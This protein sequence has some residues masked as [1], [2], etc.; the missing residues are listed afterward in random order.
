[1]KKLYLYTKL[2]YLM[3]KDR[4]YESNRQVHG[5]R[6][7][8]QGNRKG[9]AGS[10]KEGEGNR[11]VHVEMGGRNCRQTGGALEVLDGFPRGVFCCACFIKGVF[12]RPLTE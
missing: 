11:N 9:K 12:H 3:E 1:K 6:S 10:K 5:F 4:K 2:K 8:R 7:G